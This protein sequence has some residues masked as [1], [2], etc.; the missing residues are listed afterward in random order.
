MYF[1]SRIHCI[2][3]IWCFPSIQ[4]MI[5]RPPKT[6]GTHTF[7]RKSIVFKIPVLTG[8]SNSDTYASKAKEARTFIRKCIALWNVVLPRLSNNAI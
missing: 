2:L 1:K 4:R 3:K 5:S 8:Q 7:N 6:I